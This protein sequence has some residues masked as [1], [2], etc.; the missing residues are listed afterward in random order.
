MAGETREEIHIENRRLMEQ[1]DRDLKR[2]DIIY[3]QAPSG[4]GKYTFLP[5]YR[6]HVKAYQV[7]WLE[8]EK[9]EELCRSSRNTCRRGRLIII[10][11]LEE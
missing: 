7:Y 10:P 4:W 2:Y 5:D 8:E 6:A 3:L 9:V 11:R 1:L